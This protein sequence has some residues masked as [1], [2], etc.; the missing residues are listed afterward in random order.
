MT[1]FSDL[2][3]KTLLR[4]DEVAAFFSISIETLYRWANEGKLES[5]KIGKKLRFY[6]EDVVRL[7]RRG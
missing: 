3:K 4:P 2:P 7:A 1:K 6:R 5:V